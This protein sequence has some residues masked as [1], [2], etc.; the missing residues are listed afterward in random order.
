MIVS[1]ASKATAE[2]PDARDAGSSAMSAG[3]AIEFL[4]LFRKQVKHNDDFYSESEPRA[5][6][7]AFSLD[8]AASRS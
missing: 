7:S 2:G 8:F 6:L 3:E 4:R 5:L 1:I